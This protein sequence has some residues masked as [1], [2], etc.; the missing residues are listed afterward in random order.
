MTEQEKRELELSQKQEIEKGSGEP[1]REGTWFVPEV[2]ITESQEAITVLADLPGVTSENVDVDVRD[3]V[4]TLTAEV[5]P[6]LV[7]WKP[8]YREYGIGGYQR[9]FNLGERIEQA[10]ISAKL[11]NG[12]LTLM[13]PKAEAHK[14]RKITI[15]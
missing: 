14:P 15:N 10:N 3:G 12:V 7:N 6:I 1:T 9:R 8:I 2:D 5:E 13:L 11:E 4:L